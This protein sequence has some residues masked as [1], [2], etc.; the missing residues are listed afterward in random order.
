MVSLGLSSHPKKSTHMPFPP[1]FSS[2]KVPPVPIFIN[3]TKYWKVEQ[4]I[5]RSLHPEQ[6]KNIWSLKIFN[7]FFTIQPVIEY[8]F[9]RNSLKL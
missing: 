1:T 7:D 6:K 2:H 8:L 9:K 5:S 3:P 4:I